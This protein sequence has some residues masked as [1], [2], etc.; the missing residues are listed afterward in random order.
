MPMFEKPQEWSETI[1]R[2]LAEST[3]QATP[4]AGQENANP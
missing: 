2:F 4:G 3:P 1:I